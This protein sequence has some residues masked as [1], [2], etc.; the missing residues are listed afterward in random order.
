V[1]TTDP[2][3]TRAFWTAWVIHFTGAMSHAMF[4]LFPLYVLRIGGDELLIG[5]LLGVSLAVS[6]AVRPLVGVLLDRVGRR[7]VLL[8]ASLLNALSF[9][10]FLLAEEP[11]VLLWVLTVTH[12]ILGGA[13]FAS[14][15]T[16]A[17]DVIP[18]G[19]RIEGLAIFGVAG[20][21]PNG[22]APALGEALI[23][24]EGFPALFFAATGFGLVSFVLATLVPPREAGVER[25]AVQPPPGGGRALLSSLLP[26]LGAT[27]LFGAGI[28]AAFFF[29]APFTRA[30]GLDRAAPF[31]IAY[32]ATTVTLRVF[33]R[34]I[35]G[36]MG[37]HRVAIP[38]FA[39]FAV[40]LA[41]ICFFPLP[42]S[43]V[44]AGMACGA[45]HGSLFPV[46]NALSVSRAPAHLHGVVISVHT[47]ALDLG[48]VLGTPLCGAIAHT[49]GYRAMFSTV[50]AGALCGLGIML[51]DR[52]R[53]L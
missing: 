26:V 38:A 24:R 51:W 39:V 3:Y 28:N 21:A 23:A 33:G 53:R 41:G 42:G 48:G 22:L 16:Y 13:L 50:A 7:R 37:T 8:W 6:V 40:G 19:R 12:M 4:V 36:R 49:Y 30:L 2:L 1:T 46:L 5:L 27:I 44:L 32:A 18:A 20:M 47:A 52:A 14:Y 9:P 25:P 45:G 34:R 11:G 15:F 35:L 31:F 43:M 17:A 10:P 29:V